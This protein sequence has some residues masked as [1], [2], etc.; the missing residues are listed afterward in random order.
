MAEAITYAR[1]PD[2]EAGLYGIPLD[3]YTL[4]IYDDDVLLDHIKEIDTVEGWYIQFCPVDD[5]K[6]LSKDNLAIRVR[7]SKNLRIVRTH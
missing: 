6:P 4:M 2:R 3:W 5:T 7:E 1:V